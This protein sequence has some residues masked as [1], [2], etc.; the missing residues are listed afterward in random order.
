MSQIE[1]GHTKRR[2]FRVY[3]YVHHGCDTMDKQDTEDFKSLVHN[4]GPQ[5]QSKDEL[6]TKIE[7]THRV[8]T[9][10]YTKLHHEGT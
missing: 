1:G 6:I 2:S 8:R 4:Y 3:I 5:R 10:H 9:V 7:K